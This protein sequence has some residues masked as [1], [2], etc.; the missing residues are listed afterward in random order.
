MTGPRF[1][2]FADVDRFALG[3]GEHDRRRPVAGFE[4]SFRKAVTEL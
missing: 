3:V 4:R 2:S 1:R